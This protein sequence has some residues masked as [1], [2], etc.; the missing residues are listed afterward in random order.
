MLE[1]GWVP[2]QK[3]EWS[4]LEEIGWVPSEEILHIGTIVKRYQQEKQ[5]TEGG[6]K[7]D[8]IN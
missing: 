7:W 6:P 2:I 4:P 3:I 8:L 1:I 5:Q